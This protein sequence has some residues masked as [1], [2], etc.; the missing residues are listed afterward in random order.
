MLKI[1]QGRNVC[2]YVSLLHTHHK[3]YLCIVHHK[4]KDVNDER[5]LKR[6]ETN[7]KHQSIKHIYRKTSDMMSVAQFFFF[8]IKSSCVSCRLWCS[9]SDRR[10][11]REEINWHKKRESWFSSE[12][13]WKLHPWSNMS[14][15]CV[16]VHLSPRGKHL[17][18][19]ARLPSRAEPNLQQLQT[20][21]Q[22]NILSLKGRYSNLW[23]VVSVFH[24][25]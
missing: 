20:N 13:Q 10:E 3:C 16:F 18:R 19:T 7:I 15:V 12:P 25:T 1:S 2:W 9:D 5:S 22:I 4:V 14:W 24:L 6:E 23:A 8:S 21:K 11:F 17:Q